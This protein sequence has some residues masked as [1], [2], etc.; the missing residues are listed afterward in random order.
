MTVGDVAAADLRES[1]QS[2]L[3]QTYDL[4]ELCVCELGMEN[5]VA[6]VLAEFRGCD[7]RLRVLPP[8]CARGVAEATNIAAE[9]ASGELLVL[10]DGGDVLAP[11]ALREF[12]SAFCADPS[13]DVLYSDEDLIEKRGSNGMPAF[14][15]DWSPSYLE[16]AMYVGR[17]LAIRKALFWRLG[18]MRD[19]FDG[20]EDY[21]LVLR[22]SRVVR[23]V[24]HIPCVLYHRRPRLEHRHGEDA[25]L[26]APPAALAA[27]QEFAAGLEPAARVEDGLVPG[28][29]RVRRPLQP[30]PQVTLVVLTSD[31]VVQVDG[32]GRV[33]LLSNFLVSITK[34]ASCP[35]ARVLVVD[36]G[37]LSE[38]SAAALAA[39]GGQRRSFIDPLRAALGFGFARKANFALRQVTT[40]Y[41]ILLND[42]LEVISPAWIEALLEPLMD[43]GVGAVGARLLYPDGS[44][45]HAGIILGVRGGAAHCFRGQ[46]GDSVGYGRSTH[47]VREFSAV[48]GAV[49]AMRRRTF[50]ELGGFDEVFA[51]DYQDV[52][53]CARVV[54]A[55][56]RVVY[57]PFAEF[58]HF[59]GKSFLRSGSGFEQEEALFR[60]RWPELILRD[61]CYNPNL[62]RDRFDHTP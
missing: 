10:L 6:G 26:P 4:W 52:D 33:R 11:Q 59:E 49:L 36:D 42:D 37:E 51:H 43:P 16:S 35:G 46:R 25:A 45:Q 56:H 1:F 8:G 31:P 32:R 21:D 30:A 34:A 55:G 41:L 28:T 22:A 39:V 7:S 58:V 15:P 61:P 54:A 13:I 23:R 62:P 57:T 44:I 50:D 3:G 24:S 48:T 19:G 38:E 5:G 53:F 17:G 40:E 29:F 27:I 12:A 9:Q 47:V 2:V 60:E 18:G 20:A 14:K